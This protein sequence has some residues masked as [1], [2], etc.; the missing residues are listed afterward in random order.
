MTVV[1]QCYALLEKQNRRCCRASK[2]EVRVFSTHFGEENIQLYSI[3]RRM[4]TK[5]GLW[6]ASDDRRGFYGGLW[7]VVGKRGFYVTEVR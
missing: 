6:V 5:Y 1:P 7:V 3:H 2:H 4:L